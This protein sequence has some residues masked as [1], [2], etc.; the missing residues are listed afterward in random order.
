MSTSESR[1][2]LFVANTKKQHHLFLAR[3]PGTGVYIR[4]LI[5]AGGQ[6]LIGSFAPDV[7][8]K[9]VSHQERYGM[10]RAEE[11]SRQK[12]FVGL[13]YRL[14]NPVSMDTM[15]STFERND[16]Q[17]ERDS[18]ERNILTAKAVSET[19]ATDLAKRT[20]LDK[21]RVRPQRVEL[22]TVEDTPDK[23]SVAKGVEV[24][25]ESRTQPRRG[26]VSSRV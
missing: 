12:G 23:P 17:L 13:C 21:E 7:L 11:V 16:V 2:K 15:L 10:R 1:S 8:G 26:G 3:V 9:I 24:V 25:D 6:E 18:D 14:E 20:G 4:K 19:I 22:E 5:K